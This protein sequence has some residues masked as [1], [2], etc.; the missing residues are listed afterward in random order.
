MILRSLVFHLIRPLKSLSLASLKDGLNSP[1]QLYVNT[2]RYPHLLSLAPNLLLSILRPRNTVSQ[3]T[4]KKDMSLRQNKPSL[5]TSRRSSQIRNLCLILPKKQPHNNRLISLLFLSV[6]KRTIKM[7]TNLIKVKHT[8]AVQHVRPLPLNSSIFPLQ[9][10]LP[11]ICHRI[12]P[13]PVLLCA[14][15]FLLVSVCHLQDLV[16]SICQGHHFQG[17]LA[18]AIP[19][20]PLSKTKT[21]K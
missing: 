14:H 21:S 17:L 19:F 4:M 8:L 13:S 6:P 9:S 20:L 18:F 12:M 16:W 5:N 7:T 1:T 2:I 15:H 11:V 3:S 10:I